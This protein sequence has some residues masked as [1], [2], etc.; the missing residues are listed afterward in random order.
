MKS[1]EEFLRHMLT[2]SASVIDMAL[3]AMERRP[4]DAE[5][6]RLCWETLRTTA[7]D[8]RKLAT[9]DTAFPKA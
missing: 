3:D 7:E 9:S 6:K 4:D 5:R 1:E 2:M 8:L